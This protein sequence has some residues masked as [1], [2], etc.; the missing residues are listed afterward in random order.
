M[1][2]VSGSHLRHM[3]E[4]MLH[5]REFISFDLLLNRLSDANY[6]KKTLNGGDLVLCLKLHDPR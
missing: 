3:T 2:C 5:S 1:R 6:K 4:M